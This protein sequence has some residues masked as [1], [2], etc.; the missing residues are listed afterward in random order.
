[1][2]KIILYIT[3]LIL[4]S[5]LFWGCQTEC[6]GVVCF[7]E[8]VCDD[9]K[10]KCP[11]KLSDGYSAECIKNPSNMLP[12]ITTLGST[13]VQATSAKVGGNL[14]NVGGSAIID[15]GI[16]WSI[17]S[18]PSLG[19][20]VISNTTTEIGQF[21]ETI[22]GLSQSTTYYYRAYATNKSGTTY[23]GI[24]YFTTASTAGPNLV[25]VEGNVY[26]TTYIAGKLWMVQNLKV[27]KYRN[28]NSI[29]SNVSNGNWSTTNA[30]AYTLYDGLGANNNKYGKI[31][32]WHAVN[33][34]RGL[35]PTGWHIPTQQEWYDLVEAL[36]GYEVAGGKLKSTISYWNAPNTNGSNET[37]FQGLPGGK[38]T[39]DLTPTYTSEGQ[40]GY[41][42]SSTAA[43]FG[44]GHAA[45]FKL[46]YNSA[47]ADV[48]FE[49]KNFGFSVRCVKD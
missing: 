22:S 12:T 38:R 13:N 30:G 26:Q 20:N 34:P 15:K 3:L 40:E 14:V 27:S 2:K 37:N 42:W 48:S 35:A 25:D 47:A 49:E 44:T 45:Y 28:G 6:N 21:S 31:Y 11:Y 9:G 4:P 16:C 17:T 43:S 39:K 23:G 19:N 36:G 29:T 33:D 24:Q 7:N 10:C 1:M 32:N 8:A 41:F 18:T 46:S 5:I